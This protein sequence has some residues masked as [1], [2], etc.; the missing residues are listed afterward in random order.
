MIDTQALIA[1]SKG[2]EIT[3]NG[4]TEYATVRDECPSCGK[5]D[6]GMSIF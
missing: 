6:L 3:V 1:F 5:Y 4:K 2:V